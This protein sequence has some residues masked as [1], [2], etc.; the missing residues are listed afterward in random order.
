MGEMYLLH[1]AIQRVGTRKKYPKGRTII[2]KGS[3]AMFFFLVEN[4]ICQTYTIVNQKKYNLGFTFPGD[5]DGC[6]SSLLQGKPN[7]FTIESVTEVEIIICQL[8][9]FKKSLSEVAYYKIVTQVVTYYLSVIEQRLM[10]AISLTA[11]QRYLQLH[12][13]QAEKVSQIPLNLLASYLGISQER[14]S[15]IRK[16]YPHLI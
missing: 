15:R 10:D 11:E 6:P 8:Q 16:K 12:Q 3:P 13:G 5:V 14:L 4:G 9:D 7:A 1:E 2:R